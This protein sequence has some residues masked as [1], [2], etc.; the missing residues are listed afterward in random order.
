MKPYRLLFLTQS[1]ACAACL[2]KRLPLGDE[3]KGHPRRRR[4]PRR[5]EH[6]QVRRVRAA[7]ELPVEV[8]QE[9][10]ERELQGC[11]RKADAGADPPPRAER[12][13]LVVRPPH[14]HRP[15][16]AARQEPLRPELLRRVPRRGVPP[17]R[18]RVDQQRGLRGDLVPAALHTRRGH[19]FAREEE[20][21]RRVEAEHLF[22]HRP[23]VDHLVQLRVSEVR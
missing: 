23:Q 20:R 16:L 22:H 5:L 12:E 18:P 4:E 14:V 19:G 15:C 7:G 3:N 8:A 13:E 6:V 9:A 21:H 1:A 17:D 11:E 10:G 2:S